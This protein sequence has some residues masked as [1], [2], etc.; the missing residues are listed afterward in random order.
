MIDLFISYKRDER[1]FAKRLH[2]DLKPFLVPWFDESLAM[3]DDWRMV[4]TRK[5]SE[6]SCQVTL[7]SPRAVKSKFVLSEA[8]QA[9]NEAKQIDALLV[10]CDIPLPFGQR[11]VIDLTG[12][13]DNP[14]EVGKWRLLKKIAEV[15]RDGALEQYAVQELLALQDVTSANA[16]EYFD[17]AE[18]SECCDELRDDVR[19]FDPHV[20]LAPDAR[21][22]IW[23]EI[24][25]DFLQYRVPVVVDSAAER[26]NFP[27]YSKAGGVFLPELLDLSADDERILV[28]FDR[29]LS[30]SDHGR[31]VR[32]LETS[33]GF[34]PKNIMAIGLVG[35]GHQAGH[36]VRIGR[37]T[38]AR[39]VVVFY[40]NVVA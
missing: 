28:V 5:L 39:D 26:A 11:D 27:G 36:Q 29:I 17:Y 38:H 2:D 22:G 1:E 6:S 30:E 21:S 15:I 20:I 13:R 3:D 40:D 33:F 9:L 4:L 16:I 35:H 37:E 8:S 19:A 23:A 10:P 18:M 14:Q 25:F 24:F 7:W 32:A 31:V 34:S 12:W